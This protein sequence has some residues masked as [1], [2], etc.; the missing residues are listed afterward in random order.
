MRLELCEPRPEPHEAMLVRGQDL[1]GLV[2]LE[3]LER[4]E[5]VAQRI[6]ARLRVERDVRRDPGQNMVTREHERVRRLPEAE[7]PGRMPR[8]PDRRE[9][10]TRDVGL[11]AVL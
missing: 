2:A 10:P 9:I 11:V 8:R 4:V 1:V 6:G 3:L 5:V 7:M